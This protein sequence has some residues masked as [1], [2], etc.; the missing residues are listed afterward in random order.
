M[1]LLDGEAFRAVFACR[2]IRNA[3]LFRLHLGAGSSEEVTGGAGARLGVAVSRRVSKRAVERNR[4]RRQVRESFRLNRL[5]LP[6]R[7]Y[8][9]VARSAAADA[10]NPQLRQAL[11]ALWRQAAQSQPVGHRT[12]P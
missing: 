5:H 3:A 8:V 2:E 12:T 1:R 4:I 10:S 7:D 6:A 11:E 9:V